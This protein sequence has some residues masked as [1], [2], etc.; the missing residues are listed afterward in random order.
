MNENTITKNFSYNVMTRISQKADL[1]ILE[2]EGKIKIINKQNNY[3]WILKKLKK[4]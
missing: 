4:F 1:R 2:A 3:H